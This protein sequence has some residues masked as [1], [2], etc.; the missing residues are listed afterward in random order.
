[1]KIKKIII[2]S[3]SILVPIIITVLVALYSYGL[4]GTWTANQQNFID[5]IYE[6]ANTS[7]QK[8]ETFVKFNSF[9]YKNIHESVKI[10]NDYTSSN[11]TTGAN[12]NGE[13]ELEHFKMTNYVLLGNEEYKK[14]A[15]VMNAKH[16]SNNNFKFLDLVNP[17]PTYSPIGVIARSAPRLNRPMPRTSITAPMVNVISSVPEKLNQGV[18]DNR[19]T[20]AV[21]GRADTRASWILDHNS[22]K[23]PHPHTYSIILYRKNTMMPIYKL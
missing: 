12:E 15:D 20:M 22:F 18:K 14:Y 16:T 3:I 10:Y 9:Q 4:I 6:Q 11:E 19:Y 7:S 17:E 13:F 8:V 1:M 21:M 23:K 2:L 5:D